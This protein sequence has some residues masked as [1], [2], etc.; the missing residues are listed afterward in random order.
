M[1]INEMCGSINDIIKVYFKNKH[2]QNLK[3]TSPQADFEPIT[4]NMDICHECN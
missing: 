3:A 1:K 4:L 2:N